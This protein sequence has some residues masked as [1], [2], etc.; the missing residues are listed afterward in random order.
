LLFEGLSLTNCKSVKNIPENTGVPP[1]SEAVDEQ[2]EVKEDI[3]RFV[4]RINEIIRITNNALFR[5]KEAERKKDLLE[6]QNRPNSAKREAENA[7]N[8][9]KIIDGE[10]DEWARNLTPLYKEHYSSPEV[11][12]RISG[13]ER[14]EN[15]LKGKKLY[16]LKDFF[17]YVVVPVRQNS[18]VHKIE[19]VGNDGEKIKVF[20][21]DEALMYYIISD[22]DGWKI[23]LKDDIAAGII[24]F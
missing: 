4:N 6:R 8:E 19:F 20:R 10:Y 11:L 12:E 17:I 18:V 22:E 7:E 14:L 24:D 5:L 2:T 21:D 15:L 13:N 9:Q 16:N 1:T 3:V 23:D